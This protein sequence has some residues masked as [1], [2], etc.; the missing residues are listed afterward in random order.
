M[1]LKQ[2]GEALI[3]LHHVLPPKSCLIWFSLLSLKKLDPPFSALCGLRSLLSSASLSRYPLHILPLQ[4]MSTTCLRGTSQTHPLSVSS[5]R[6]CSVRTEVQRESFLAGLSTFVFLWL[7]EWIIMVWLDSQPGR[8]SQQR[9]TAS[10]KVIL[11]KNC[12]SNEEETRETFC[13]GK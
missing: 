8:T 13:L 12:K 7:L 3:T 9:K 11:P 10:N 1:K 6:P 5:S 2:P 4:L